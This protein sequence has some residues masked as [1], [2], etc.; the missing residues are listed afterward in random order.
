MRTVASVPAELLADDSRAV[1]S[2]GWRVG[3]FDIVSAARRLL[4]WLLQQRQRVLTAGTPRRLRVVETVSLGEKRFVSI[5]KVDGEQF[6]IGASTSNVALLAK[7]DRD[8]SAPFEDVLA[9][10]T[11][12]AEDHDCSSE[13][14]R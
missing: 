11:P 6:L 4:G 7:L 12:S 5:L 13:A 8:R 1:A 9:G 10:S 14:P 2:S 3:R